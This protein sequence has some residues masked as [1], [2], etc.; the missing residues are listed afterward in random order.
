MYG[1]ISEQAQEHIHADECVLT[2]GHSHV[3]E[4]FLKAAARKRRFQVIVAEGAP[5]LSGHRLAQ[6]LSRVSNISVS[7]IPD[8]NVYAIMSRINKV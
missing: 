6:S 2:H 4:L 8:S 7:L 3:I 1:P 5:S